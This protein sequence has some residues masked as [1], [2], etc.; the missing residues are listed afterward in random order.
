[1]S[2]VRREGDS[3]AL[4]KEDQSVYVPLKRPPVVLE[5]DLY[6]DGLSEV[7]KR[8]FFP[9]SSA[10]EG[11]ESTA[12]SSG[13]SRH[14][15]IDGDERIISSAATPSVGSQNIYSVD[16]VSSTPVAIAQT[17]LSLSQY[18]AKY[19]SEDN[20]SF[21]ELLDKQNLLKREK[22]AWH[23]KGNKIYSENTERQEQRLQGARLEEQKKI[24]WID[25]R[26]NPAAWTVTPKNAL[27]FDPDVI[28]PDS[29]P[30]ATQ[31]QIHLKATRF[32][33]PGSDQSRPPSPSMSTIHRAMQGDDYDD[34]DDEPRVNGYTFIDEP[35]TPY[36][37]SAANPFP[38]AAS[39]AVRDEKPNPFRIPETPARDLLLERLLSK[40]R[41]ATTPR[42]TST[43]VKRTIATPKFKS[44]PLLSPAAMRIIR[45][46]TGRAG[47][48]SGVSGLRER[49]K[50]PA[51]S[52][53][54]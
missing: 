36:E 35:E 5:E 34:S 40:Q 21:L 22:Y 27:M 51:K 33:K 20:A 2:L 52:R 37:T 54:R 43:V 48:S 3:K 16:A 38:V 28:V 47:S 12:Q 26:M 45:G 8:N 4:I 13:R 7:I 25:D 11:G 9:D 44:S 23:Y 46:G 24:G 49:L 31:T 30:Q 29:Q 19:T 17:G 6:I 53:L 14:H 50:T 41:R 32:Q 1:M 10:A 42:A 39:T 15:H 18:Q